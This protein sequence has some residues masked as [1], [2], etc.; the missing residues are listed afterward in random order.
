MLCELQNDVSMSKDSFIYMEKSIEQLSKKC[1][2]GGYT[3]FCSI[4]SGT[5]DKVECVFAAHGS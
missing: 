1:N 2:N 4:P 5:I 3:F